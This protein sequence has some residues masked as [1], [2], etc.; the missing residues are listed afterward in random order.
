M[1]SQQYQNF[2]DKTMLHMLRRW[3]GSLIIACIYILR[4]YLSQG[5]YIVS[6]G[7]RIYM[8][9]LFI[10]F[11]SPQIDPEIQELYNSAT[12]PTMNF[13]EFCPFV[14]RLP[15]FK[16]YYSIMASSGWSLLF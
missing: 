16:F 8:L 10:G 15:K 2:L 6:Y 7:L 5:F 14:C 4:V 13:D 1:V 3:I 9:N 11:L 12:L